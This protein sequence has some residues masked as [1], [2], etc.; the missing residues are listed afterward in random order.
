M[1]T[2]EYV[3]S[4]LETSYKIEFAYH[5]TELKKIPKKLSNVN[6]TEY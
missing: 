6:S 2:E 3:G 5:S 1:N 4:I